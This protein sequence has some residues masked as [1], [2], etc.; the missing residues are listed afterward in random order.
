MTPD[1]RGFKFNFSNKLFVWKMSRNDKCDLFPYT[2]E[3]SFVWFVTQKILFFT[4][5]ILGRCNIHFDRWHCPWPSPW[6]WTLTLLTST[7]SWTRVTGL[8]EMLQSK[9][10]FFVE[11]WWWKC[12]WN[13]L[14]V[15]SQCWWY[16]L[17]KTCT[18]FRFST[19]LP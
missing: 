6:H 1:L 15:Y 17:F 12:F 5:H 14:F 18:S 11:W 8:K 19:S 4:H 2:S 3:A 16:I 9:K 13:E 10:T 7:L